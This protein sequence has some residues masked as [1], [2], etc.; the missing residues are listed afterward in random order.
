LLREIAAELDVSTTTVARWLDP[1]KAQR[2]RERARDAKLARRVPCERCNRPLGYERAGGLCRRCTSDDAHAR[3]ERVAA[4]Y[5]AGVEAPEI[6]RQ[7]GLAEGYVALLL[8]RLGHAGRI[9]LRYVPRDRGSARERERQI[10]SLR[11]EG[12]SRAEIA[13]RVGLTPGSLGVA[14]A[15]MRARDAPSTTAA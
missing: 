11:D 7:V 5:D 2:M 9:T 8:T 4:L 6:A 14:I 15:R 12:L 3:I 10:A 13:D 1:A